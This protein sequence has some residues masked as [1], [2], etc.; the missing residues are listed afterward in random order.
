[1]P[2]I[3]TISNRPNRHS[4]DQVSSLFADCIMGSNA[5]IKP[6]SPHEIDPCIPPATHVKT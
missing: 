2:F 3:A 5:I 1:M 4:V 6:N